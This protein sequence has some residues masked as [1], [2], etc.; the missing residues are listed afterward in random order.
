MRSEA[1]AREREIR[2][3]A[4]EADARERDI[5]EMTSEAAD[6]NRE[7]RE[8][9]SEGT[10]REREI[11]DLDV[12]E[13]RHETLIARL[14]REAGLRDH[15]LEALSAR[16]DAA[17]H[18]LQDLRAIRD[19]LTPP[20]L[21]Q[22]PG[23]DLA[24][25]FVPAADQVSGD[26]YL[27]AAG[28]QDST[29]LVVGDVMGHGLHTGR[30]ATF[31]RTAFAATAAFSDDPARL[32]SWANIALVERAGVGSEFVTAACLTYHPS[33]Q[34]LR[35]AYAG[36]PPALWMD[37]GAPLAAGYG[38]P[39][40]IYEN[41]EYAEGSCRCPPPPVGVLLYTDGLIEARRDGECFGMARV[42]VALAELDEPSASEATAMLR[43]RV[44]EFAGDTL[45]DDLCML[46]ARIA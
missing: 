4:S 17:E 7:I 12:Q 33:Q 21:P 28:P 25:A 43:E 19:A 2:N 18:E 31:I 34:I 9:T 20:E 5:R 8:M 45:D 39:L 32:L 29:V 22:R 42:S 11:H 13:Q 30:R 24:A 15:E 41:P 23:L 14:R 37:G 36:H 6:R 10:D 46:A 3:L 27:A 1:A 44:A 26:F 40:G 16:L 38:F 35:F